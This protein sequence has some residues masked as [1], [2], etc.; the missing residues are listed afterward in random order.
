MDFEVLDLSQKT[1]WKEFYDHLPSSQKDIL[2]SPGYYEAFEIRN[3]GKARCFVYKEEDKVALY[4]FLLNSVNDLGYDLPDQYFDIQGTYG[5]NGI[6][7]NSSEINFLKGFSK[8]FLEFAAGENIIAEFIRFNPVLANQSLSLYTEPIEQL[9]NVLI[10]LNIS[11]EEI[12]TGSYDRSVRNAVRKAEKFNLG[13]SSFFGKDL[14]EDWLHHF[15]VIFHM[16]MN[17]NSASD[18]Y[19]FEDTFFRNLKDLLPENSLFSFASL[20]GV[21]ISADLILHEGEFAYGLFGGTDAEKYFC[22]PNSFIRH[23][24]IMQLKSMDIKWYSIGG[25]HQRNDSIYKYKKSFSTK[26]HSHF[27]IG[28]KIHNALIYNKVVDQWRSG[29]PDKT[30]QYENHLLCYRYTK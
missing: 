28:R 14:D 12:W 11:T 20:D 3:E 5:Y 10:D 8:V 17:R 21:P 19:Y 27:Y 18:Y 22:S 6:I 9:D 7:T 2:S 1:R 24:E 13:Y 15:L 26:I 29:F 16:T 25:G 30:G 4:P 23:Q